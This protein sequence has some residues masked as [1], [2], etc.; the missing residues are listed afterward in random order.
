M[1]RHIGQPG[2]PEQVV[3]LFARWKLRGFLSGLSS[4]RCDAIPKGG[5]LFETAVQDVAPIIRLVAA[6][7]TGRM[8]P[9]L[10]LALDQLFERLRNLP[11]LIALN[12]RSQRAGISY[13]F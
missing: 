8:I 6:S 11:L 1:G 5:G 4:E 2:S 9:Y 12:A 13:C 10:D 7:A 3:L